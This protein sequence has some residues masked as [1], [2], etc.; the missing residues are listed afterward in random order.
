M[1][2]RRFIV[3]VGASA[4][5]SIVLPDLLRQFTAQMN[6]AVFVVLHLSK[7]P[8]G[9]MLVDRLQKHTAF[10]C[11]LPRNKEVIKTGHVYVAP[12]DHHMII[13]GNK[14]LLGKGPLENR[15]RP[16]IDALF[17]SA[18]VEYDSY[19]IGIILSG[20]LED[21]VSGMMAIRRSGGMCI[22]QQPEEAKHPDMP[23]AV[24]RQLK[25]DFA[26]PVEEMGKAIL[27][28][29][30]KPTKK[31]KIPEELVKEARI[32]ER[33]SIGIDQLKEIGT[34]SLYS[35]P[36]CGGGLWEVG[37]RGQKS[38]RCHVGHAYSED[39]LLSAMEATT[40]SALWTALRIIEERS[41]LLKGIIAGGKGRPQLHAHYKNRIA[42]LE[43]QI[44]QIKKVLFA[45]SD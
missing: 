25:P 5:G 44:E 4:G 8:V 14:I 3:V 18:A 16:S 12:P 38:Y 37:Q 19:T 32:A 28:I 1:A 9:D 23:L 26:I 45:T 10:T 17:R 31:K 27:D 36:D 7:K 22:I 39:S 6:V 35:C 24:S 40:E 33:V 34:N 30:T 43:K 42:E 15:Y 41:Q 21:G 20:L 13:K 11:K 29:S 2:K